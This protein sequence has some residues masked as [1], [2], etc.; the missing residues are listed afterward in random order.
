MKAKAGELKKKKNPPIS[1]GAHPMNTDDPD[2]LMALMKK[3]ME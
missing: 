1:I 2:K 3:G